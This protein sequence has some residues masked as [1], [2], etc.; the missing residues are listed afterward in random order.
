MAMMSTQIRQTARSRQNWLYRSGEN[1]RGTVRKT[2][3]GFRRICYQA[4]C[5]SIGRNNGIEH[6][7]V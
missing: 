5:V 4:D 6:R 1:P 2:I 3:D 7:G